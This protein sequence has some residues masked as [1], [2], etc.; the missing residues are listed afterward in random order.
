M[1]S[2]QIAKLV[3]I[4]ALTSAVTACG[5]SSSSADETNP[6]NA[7]TLTS[8]SATAD[9]DNS[10]LYRFSW[11]V[12]DVDGDSLSCQLNPG[13]GEPSIAI[14]D[15][16]NITSTQVTYTKAGNYT[17]N[18]TVSD[19][20]SASA[21]GNLD[22]VVAEQVVVLPEPVVSASE[23]QMVIFYNRQDGLYDDWVLHLWNN[24]SCDA[25]ADFAADGGT[26]WA[27]GQAQTG[28]DPNYGAYWLI[29]LKAGYS[30]CANFIVHQGDDKDLGGSDHQADLSGARMIWSLSG[31]SEL[32]YQKTLFP[33]SIQIKDI[34]AHWVTGDYV[35]WNVNAADVAKVRVYS[36]PTDDL[37]FDGES[38]ISG[39]NYIEFYPVVSDNHPAVELAMPRYQGQA[40]F[41]ADSFAS[42]SAKQMLTGKLLAIAYDL[43]NSVV[44][45]TYVQT[46]RVLDALYTGN[47][48][49][50]DEATLGLTYDGNDID[51]ALWA[52]TA[53]QVVMNIYDA[54]K[55]LLTSQPMSR[56]FDTGIWSVS[57]DANVDRLFYLYELTVYHHQNQRI[58]TITSTD[59]YS[60]SLATNGEYSQFVNLND[61]DLM[62]S[63][64]QQHAIS[65]VDEPQDAVIYEGHIRDFS[66]LDSSTSVANR[67]K[68]LAFT[69]ENSV[70]VKHL[71]TLAAAGLTH[72]Q[73]L[74]ANDIASID[75]DDSSRINL[76]STVN[77]LCAKNANAPVCGVADASASLLSV[78]ASY[79]PSSTDAQALV[80]SMRSLDSFN[81]GY[82][83]KHF[84]APDGSY[85]SNPDG[86]SRIV[87]MRSMNQ[88]L[89]AMGLRVVLDVVFNHTNSSGLY[90][91]SVLDKV[92]PGYYHRRDLTT[93]MVLQETCCQDTAPEHR[94]M[95]KLMVDSLLLWT[96]A[97]K[98]DGFR[99]DIM[100][101]NTVESIL[102]AREQVQA[103]DE[104]NYFY[105]EGWTRSEQGYL[106]AQQ[107]NMAGSQVGT[108]NDRPRD[109]I[110][111]ASLFKASGSLND[112]DIV[113]L[114]LA[115]TLADYALQDKNGIVK[116]GQDFSQASYGKHPAD[117]INY[118][119]KHDNETL[120]DQLQYGL[121]SS[122]SV[123][124]RVR[125]QNMA[126]TLPLMSQGISFLQL[127]GDL[128]RSKSMDRNTYDAGDWFNLVDF[129]KTTN[130]WNVGLPLAEDNQ[131]KWST[132]SG[133]ISNS[134]SAVQDHHIELASAVFNEF[135]A[136][137]SSSKLFRLSSVEDVIDRVGFHNTGVNQV[138]GLIVMSLDDGSGLIDL[139]PN[140][141]AIVVVINGSANEQAH[142]IL[143]ANN[144][145]LHGLQQA[146]ADPRVKTA[147][148]VASANA[149]TF[150]VPAFTS[151]VFVQPQG[152]SQG[153]G[154]AA[155]VTLNQA[156]IAPYGDTLVYLRGSMNNWGNDG[157]TAADN[158]SYD[159]NDIYSLAVNLTAG[160]H[161]F[162]IASGDWA[163]VNLGFNEVTFA[164]GAIAT[165]DDGGNIAF[166]VESDSLYSFT[167]DASTPTP[168]LNIVAK[169]ESLDCDLL[170]DSS[171]D[172]PFSVAGGGGL[173]VRGSH[174][175]WNAD[176]TYRLHYKGNN[177]YQAV[178]DFD[179]DLQFKLASDDGSWSTQ[180]WA[181][182]EASEQI[183]SNN[184][185]VGVRY[186]V[187]FNDAGTD[188]NQTN[189]AAGSYS[190]L[191][192]LNTADPSQGFAV[193]DLIIQQCQ[194]K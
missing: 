131:A 8:F 147:S 18:L 6:N 74:P 44:A 91:D 39:D 132:I 148:F 163:A 71:K 128:I 40:A 126:A 24:A 68:Y 189:L 127:G 92:V 112:Q 29:D 104:D 168:E 35:F 83:P 32:F 22:V 61:S 194:P 122:V 3:F 116:L 51:A 98:F 53:Q 16:A 30:D 158:F 139:D 96:S 9:A 113:R 103:I 4:T 54:N 184:L 187:A 20:L 70:P 25:Y 110:R 193:G 86:E 152:A 154:L 166:T 145:Q 62:P 76:T 136:I 7:P 78:F 188:N 79:E 23:Q 182:A 64:W 177:T 59:P 180:L 186:L 1:F 50:A 156:D 179:G 150:I 192:T 77:E 89:H 117:I 19:T 33:S 162:K 47:S 45:A 52:P 80:Q 81:W 105:G 173:Y 75:E 151:A 58:E 142:T 85:A 73:M 123:D 118:V 137:R 2:N 160:E 111:S 121:E 93:G 87:E 94:M 159:D 101:N 82:D 13:D 155:D 5:G 65:E 169:T 63:G 99:F 49:D 190:F 97:Y 57:L 28:I 161:I 72:F 178:A 36:S 42:A 140:H 67:G 17:A 130:N 66:V 12:A 135:L 191:L 100:S 90:A 56:N 55:Q 185:E 141:D 108:F 183:N 119:S 43:D 37:G 164:P 153:S 11:L 176:E 14:S 10:L 88:A 114:G 109:T 134:E 157:L 124:D 106:Q 133:L 115:G 27:Q 165:F 138:Q 48:N 181:Q 170:V 174:S 34:A 38:G 31:F 107:N 21:S 84:F 125:I 171:E 172:A 144:F 143:T 69:E 41:K 120:W 175:G 15:C 26:E 129:T 95:D 46:P 167:L 102:T 149:G 146:S 60:V